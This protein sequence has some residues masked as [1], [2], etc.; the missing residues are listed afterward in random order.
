MRGRTPLDC[1]PGW[2]R[3]SQTCR[4]HPSPWTACQPAERRRS[5]SGLQPWRPRDARTRRRELGVIAAAGSRGASRGCDGRSGA[6]VDQAAV[7]GCTVADMMARSGCPRY[8]RL[9]PLVATIRCAKVVRRHGGMLAGIRVDKYDEERMVR[10][11]DDEEEVCGK[12]RR[13]ADRIQGE[14]TTTSSAE[15]TTTRSIDLN[16]K[17]A[18]KLIKALEPYTSAARRTD[19]RRSGS[20]RSTRS[21]V[22]REQLAKMRTWGKANGYKVSERGRVSAELQQAYHAANRPAD[23]TKPPS[24]HAGMGGFDLYQTPPNPLIITP[25]PIAPI[26]A[27]TAHRPS[28][29]SWH[30]IRV[31]TRHGGP[32]ARIGGSQESSYRCTCGGVTVPLAAERHSRSRGG[33]TQRSS[34]SGWCTTLILRRACR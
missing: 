18:Q 30:S 6:A 33:E 10:R 34:P 15:P 16:S 7:C 21:G 13:P 31:K 5:A 27:G 19:G 1:I 26:D 24:P 8:L 32:A 2:H 9:A 25:A 22:G 23:R 28:S 12:K 11:I 20:S 17:N 29:R 4:G 3:D 14:Y